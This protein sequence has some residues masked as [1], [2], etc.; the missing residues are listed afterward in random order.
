MSAPPTSSIV[1][2]SPGHRLDHFGAGDEHVGVLPRHDDEVHQRRRVGGT[3]GARAADDGDLRHDA[4][5]Q[6]VAVEDLAVAGQGVDAFLDAC[7]AGVLE[8]H[9]RNAGLDGELH[10]L[11]DLVGVHL[12]Q[13]AGRDGEVLAERGHRP[14]VHVAGAG[15]HAVGGIHL[16]VGAEGA[17]GVADVHAD[18]LEGARLEQRA[19]PVAGGEQPLG[20]ALVDLLLATAKLDGAAAAAQ[21]GNDLR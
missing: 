11:D 21:L 8:R 1:A 14:A 12:A 9:Q 5:H 10:Q 18:F 3:A 17:T 6:D 4:G 7:A 2:V 16:L 15:D 13:R 19:Q 20:V